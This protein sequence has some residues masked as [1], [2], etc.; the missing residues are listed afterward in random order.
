M[1][2]VCQDSFHFPGID[3]LIGSAIKR[4]E[5]QI[6]KVMQLHIYPGFAETTSGFEWTDGY[7]FVLLI[8]FFRSSSFDMMSVSFAVLLR[9]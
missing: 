7:A 4:Y 6:S 3:V 9:A 8:L 1:I 5:F 2:K